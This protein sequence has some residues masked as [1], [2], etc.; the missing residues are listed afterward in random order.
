MTWSYT[1]QVKAELAQTP[2]R[3]IPRCWAELWGMSGQSEAP[4]VDISPWV[5]GG[6]AIVI[7]RGFRLMKALDLEPK[8]RLDPHHSRV[9]FTLW[10]N[11]VPPPDIDQSVADCPEDW[12]RGAFL[13]R[14]YV[15]EID[16]PVH[17]EIAAPNSEWAELAARAMDE[18]DVPVHMSTRRR[19]LVL[20]LKDRERVA[21]VLARIGAP[22]SLLAMQ[23]ESVVREMK[24]QVNRLVNSETANMKR[25]VDAAIRD[26][27]AIGRLKATGKFQD[28]SPDLRIVADL[29][30][31]HPDWSFE[32]LGRHVRPPI[33]KSA[34]NHR[35]RRIRQQ[36]QEEIENR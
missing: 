24:N 14:G 1:R 12:L 9:E 34:V 20:Y 30:L 28:L 2:I 29:R 32:E 35:L 21:Y 7:R 17:W 22:Q 27:Q 26:G 5:R 6:V 18:M 8:V 31:K 33:S 10:G 19:Q 16:R 3:S 23:S 13:T 25:I 15:S 4:D 11:D 36:L